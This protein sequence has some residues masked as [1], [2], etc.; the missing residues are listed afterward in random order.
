MIK[1]IKAGKSPGPDGYGIEFYKTFEQELTPILVDLCQDIKETDADLFLKLE[2]YFW[3]LSTLIH[4][5]PFGIKGNELLL[6]QILA[7]ASNYEMPEEINRFPCKTCVVVGNGYSIK[8]SSLGKEIN[9]YEVVIRL[10]Q[11]PVRGYE[12][13]VGNKTTMRLFYP[14]SAIQNIYDHDTPDTLQV[15]VPYKIV[16]GLWKSAPIVWNVSPTKIR[17]LHPY[18]N[19]KA[20]T[21]LLGSS[22]E[23][24]NFFAIVVHNAIH[25]AT[26]SNIPRQIQV[27]PHKSGQL[28][29]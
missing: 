6:S 29:D 2:N 26:I 21:E 19:L 14:E 5:L 3:T 25:M 12:Q 18:M 8:N 17:I 22:L 13:D 24:D 16:Q 1:E 15:L 4:S 23:D 7:K 20:G 9:K 27:E 10:N 11:G 28:G